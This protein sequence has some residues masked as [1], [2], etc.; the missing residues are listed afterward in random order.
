MA[1]WDLITYCK[2]TQALLAEVEANAPEKVVKDDKGNAVGVAF[3]KTP[4]VRNGTETLAVVRADDKELAFITSLKSLKVLAKVAAGGD[5][6]AAMTKTNK[7][8]YDKVYPQT[9]VDILDD[10]GNVIGQYTPPSL[11]GA[12]L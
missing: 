10:Q 11:I 3:T 8:L 1:Y 9:P 7:A 12:F 5:L 6:L 4:T 2:D